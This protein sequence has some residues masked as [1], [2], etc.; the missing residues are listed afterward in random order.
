MVKYHLEGQIKSLPVF[1]RC[2][3]QKCTG[4]ALI[5]VM[6]KDSRNR[7]TYSSTAVLISAGGGANLSFANTS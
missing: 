2:D 3:K 5:S 7:V 4:E 1:F 6:V